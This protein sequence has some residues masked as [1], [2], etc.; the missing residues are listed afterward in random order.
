MG[1]GSSNSL[2]TRTEEKSNNY[3]YTPEERNLLANLM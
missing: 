1:C 3:A 2:K